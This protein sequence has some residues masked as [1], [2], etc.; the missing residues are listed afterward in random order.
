MR[1]AVYGII[2]NE[3]WYHNPKLYNN[4]NETVATILIEK[5]LDVP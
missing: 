5:G 3:Y 4:Y 2:P 1:I